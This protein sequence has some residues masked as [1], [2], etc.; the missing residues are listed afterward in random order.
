MI[1]RK[2][3]GE[4][5]RKIRLKIGFSQKDVARALHCS[6]SAYSYKENGETGFSIEEI[7]MLTILF[8]VDPALFFHPENL[9]NPKDRSR[10]S[11]GSSQN[12]MSVGD[13]SPGERELICQLRSS[14]TFP[15]T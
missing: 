2:E 3:F 12:I 10:P 4:N 13:L 15:L 1:T 5:I 6:R 8:A 14:P 11:R 9:P 7:Q